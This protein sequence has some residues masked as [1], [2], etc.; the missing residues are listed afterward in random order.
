[1]TILPLLSRRWR[2]TLL[3]TK[4]LHRSKRVFKN[5]GTEVVSKSRVVDQRHYLRVKAALF[6]S[7]INSLPNGEKNV[8]EWT[9][10]EGDGEYARFFSITHS[11]GKTV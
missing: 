9:Y 7:F 8:I 2:F 3:M 6:W 4:L 1:M 10:T 11:L 5:A